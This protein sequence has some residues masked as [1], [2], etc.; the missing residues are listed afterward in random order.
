M[1]NARHFRVIEGSKKNV[2]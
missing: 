1:K 2:S